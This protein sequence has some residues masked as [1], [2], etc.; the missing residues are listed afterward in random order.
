MIER[1]RQSRLRAVAAVAIAAMG[2]QAIAVAPALAQTQAQ[3]Q[4]GEAAQP[5]GGQPEVVRPEVRAILS[6]YGSFTQHPRYGEVWVPSVTPQGW[7]PYPPCM[8]VASKRF[9]WY[10]NDPSPWGAI[11]HHYGRW[12]HD[13]Q[14]GWVWVPGN[15]FSPGWVL[16]RTSKDYVGWAPMLPEQDV[17]TISVTAFDNSDEWLFMEVAKFGKPCSGDV[18]VPAPQIATLLRRTTYVT[19]IEYVDGIA[20]FVL[21]PWI[22]GEFVDIDI[23]FDPWPIYWFTQVIIDWN[24]VW[25]HT[26]IY[27][28]VKVCT[29]SN[30]NGPIPLR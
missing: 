9:G 3:A 21:P 10:F 26:T 17:Q 6:Q 28:T 30:P 4:Q 15:E 29:P 13:P 11:V 8:W 19:A 1:F 12:G 25:H 2:I 20:I 27:E 16:W 18:L 5:G 14:M 7:H 22:V 24:W 23:T